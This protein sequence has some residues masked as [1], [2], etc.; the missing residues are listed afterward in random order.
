MPTLEEMAFFLLIGTSLREMLNG[1]NFLFSDISCFLSM[2]FN[3]SIG[4]LLIESSLFGISRVFRNSEKQSL[5]ELKQAKSTFF[6]LIKKWLFSGL[7]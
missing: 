7:C 2:N 4:T 3:D 1:L 6:K 5:S